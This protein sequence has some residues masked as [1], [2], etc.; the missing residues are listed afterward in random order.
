MLSMVLAN[1][2]RRYICNFMSHWFKH[3]SA[4]DYRYKVEHNIREHCH[5]SWMFI[6]IHWSQ[7]VRN[8]VQCNIVNAMF[9]RHGYKSLFNI[10]IVMSMLCLWM[11]YMYFQHLSSCCYVIQCDNRNLYPF[12][13]SKVPRLLAISINLRGHLSAI[14]IHFIEYKSVI[15]KIRRAKFEKKMI[16]DIYLAKLH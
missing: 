4:I 5:C 1:K 10:V 8:P 7:T 3:W 13:R 16:N 9:F 2:K 11:K 15:I 14:K 12:K 6:L